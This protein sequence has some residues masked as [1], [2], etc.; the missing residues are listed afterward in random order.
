MLNILVLLL[1]DVI[2]FG[3]IL[4]SVDSLDNGLSLTPV[5]GWNSWNHFHCDVSEEL[6]IET[7][8]IIVSTG[9]KDLGYEY[10]NID[11]CWQSAERDLVTRRIEADKERFPNGLHYLSKYAHSKGL[12]LGIYSSA[13][14]KTCQAFPA[15]LGLEEVDA[16]MYSEYEIDYLK[17]DN[18]YTDQGP[19]QKRYTMMS[20]A[21]QNSGRNMVY[22]LCEWGRENPAVWASDISNS[23]RVSGDISD[24]FRS[25]LTRA[26]YDASL[27]R[28]ARPGGFNDP[29]MLEVGNGGCSVDEYIYH[30]SLWSFLKS[31]LIIGNDV[32][33]LNEKIKYVDP[34]TNQLTATELSTYEI[35]SNK[36]IIA[37]NQDA[38][39]YQA[40]RIW[41]DLV[42]LQQDMA[43]DRLIATKCNVNNADSYLD[44]F[45]D[46][47][48]EYQ[49][50]S[51]IK[52]L[53]TNLCLHEFLPRELLNVSSSNYYIENH[54][55]MLNIT[56]LDHT[57]GL[58][59]VGTISCDIATRW[60]MN[61]YVGG[62]IVSKTT[63]R[64]LEVSKFEPLPLVQGNF[65]Q[66]I[67]FI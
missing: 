9:L 1:V 59:T 20:K 8:D 37:I 22:S 18:C 17:Y 58:Y 44:K 13:G 12:K 38:L 10:V 62:S 52:S 49:N 11:D 32:R 29:D 7:I 67:T 45:V 2:L 19:P 55:Y 63:N 28:Y 64:C 14:F 30:F 53:S 65:I 33:S 36:E 23:W 24:N 15:S 41:S 39:G 48:W 4:R 46:Q 50:D 16:L 54:D 60:E 40:R 35:I 3:E 66:L 47:Q 43:T 42:P 5:M 31:P 56:P 57:F 26:A 51:T 21:L 6:L 61:A 25:I 34:L 27:W